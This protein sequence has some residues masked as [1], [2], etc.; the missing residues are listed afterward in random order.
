MAIIPSL[1][2]YTSSLYTSAATPQSSTVPADI[3]IAPAPPSALTPKL[4]KR[5][6]GPEGITSPAQAAQIA[7]DA[8]QNGD[9]AVAQFGAKLATNAP[10]AKLIAGLDSDARSISWLDFS[11]LAK[12]KAYI[13]REDIGAAPDLTETL[14]SDLI[15]MAS[16]APGASPADQWNPYG[17]I[18]NAVGQQGYYPSQIPSSY[19]TPPYYNGV[20]NGVFGNLAFLSP[21]EAQR[22]VQMGQGFIPQAQQLASFQTAG[23]ANNPYA[24]YTQPSS[25][26][27][28]NPSIFSQ[29][30]QYPQQQYLTA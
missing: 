10:I 19:S 27:I 16:L 8:W 11:K 20:L 3:G 25:M 7:L 18:A 26:G 13:G 2:S 14:K 15:A 22:I 23:V 21:G 1:S 29:Q 9:I 6:I 30:Q 17:T 24:A 28:T 4:L 12:G 5:Y